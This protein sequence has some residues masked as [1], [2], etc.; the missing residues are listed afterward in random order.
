MRLIKRLA[1]LLLCVT[2]MPIAALADG[3]AGAR[4]DLTFAMDPAAC[5]DGEDSLLAQLA[6]LLSA[7]T[8]SGT[9]ATSGDCFDVNSVW[10]LDGAA[11]TRTTLRLFGLPSHYGVQS[12]LLGDETVMINVLALLEFAMKTY[13]HLDLPLQRAA[14]LAGPYVHTSAFEAM[15]AV[16]QPVLD[17]SGSRTVAREDVLSL[18]ESLS[19]LGRD[20]RAFEYWVRA[21][22]LESGYDEAI[23]SF[24]DELPDWVD[25]FL[26]E[27]G[28]RITAEN[29]LER[30]ETGDVTLF[31]RD[32]TSW[33]LTL[34]ASSEGYAL[35]ASMT[36]V[37]SGNAVDLAVTLDVSCEEPGDVL[38]LRLTATGLPGTLSAAPFTLRYDATGDAVGEAGVHASLSGELDGERA[39]LRLMNPQTGVPFLTVSGTLV[40]ETPAVAPAFTPQDIDG[41]NILSVNDN[42]L[43]EFLS[44]VR[45]PL[46]HG[47]LPLLKHAPAVSCQRLMDWFEASGILGL[48]TSGAAGEDEPF[49]DEEDFGDY[50]GEDE[51]GDYGEFD[52]F[53][54]DDWEEE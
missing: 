38:A 48:V 34:P 47:L 45:S 14:L 51:Y 20:D 18:A 11:E 53:D 29:G 32:A 12:S 28:L 4:F 9:I 39:S 41:V 30:W 27:D 25:G 33:S 13:A 26:G 31:Q 44:A 5:P 6:P 7:L 49:G 50:G 54:E 1:A 10:L 37:A 8:V 17:G 19:A 23:F 46:L 3:P 2:L 21:V 42:S 15:A 24:L 36:R 16:W 52:E 22:A 43:S 35:T 40:P